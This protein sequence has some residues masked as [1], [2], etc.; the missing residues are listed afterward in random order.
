V[1][2]VYGNI[3]DLHKGVIAHGVNT[4]GVAGA[5]IAKAIRER[6]PDAFAPYFTECARQPRRSPGW[7]VWGE[8]SGVRVWHLASQDRPG[9]RARVEWIE[10]AVATM[11]GS[12]PSREIFIPKLGCGIGGLD[13]EDVASALQFLDNHNR[14]R[15]CI[16]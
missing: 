9:K 4:Q 2:E 1:I 13:W 11:L 8:Q 6:L 15:V 10:E 7:A 12:E 5:G 14:L 16:L 3:F